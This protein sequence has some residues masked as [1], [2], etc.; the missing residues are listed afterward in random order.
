MSDTALPIERSEDGIVT[1]KLTPNPARPRGGVVVLDRWLID[2]VDEAMSTIAAGDTPTGFILA[3]ASE[4]VFV[5]GADLA[6]IEEL[7]DQQLKEYLQRGAAT[8]QRIVELPCTT[9]AAINGATLGGGLELALH[10]DGLVAAVVPTDSKPWRIGLPEAGLGL[11]P[12]WGGTQTLPAR[13][14][15]AIAIQSAAWSTA[16][17]GRHRRPSCGDAYGHSSGNGSAMT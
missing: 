3:S 17:R 14:D 12:G 11:C 9:A 16:A 2:A 10:C 6:E 13:I 1:L 8:W 15:P 7:D 5:A 4:R